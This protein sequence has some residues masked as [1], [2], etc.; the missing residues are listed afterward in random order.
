MRVSTKS[1]ILTLAL[2]AL[3]C[4]LPA[5]AHAEAKRLILKDGTYQ[6]VTKYE[7]KGDRVRYLSADRFEWEEVPKDLVDWPATEKWEKDRASAA[8]SQ[9]IKELA[10]ESEAERK[11]EEARSPTVAPGLRLPSQGGV[12][13]LDDF[14]GQKQ[15]AELVQSGSE[16]NKQTG[17]NILRATL[18]P[19]S[20]TRQS[21]ELKGARAGVQAHETQPVMYV[22]VESDSE[23]AGAPTRVSG[24]EAPPPPAQRYRIVRLTRKKD[25]RVVGNLKIALT[26]SLKQQETFV[27]V[28]TTVMPGGWMKL[29]PAAPL[30]PGEYAVVEMLSPKEINLY[31]WDFGVDPTA[32]ANPTAWKP[33]SEEGSESGT[34]QAPALQN[35]PP[36]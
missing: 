1:V 23:D 30:P 35:R 4:L 6:S 32:P 19:F 18:N 25:A 33:V 5:P 2:A 22:N 29:M 27:E 21:I 14:Q 7:I 15:L 24:Q 17:K 11:E 12:Y 8:A 9:E 34:T 16:L 3:A 10:E 31:V 26:G 36:K 13:L 20:G 28:A